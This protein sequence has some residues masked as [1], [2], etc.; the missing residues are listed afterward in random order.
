MGQKT[1]IPGSRGTDGFTLPEILISTTIALIVGA[2]A[3]TLLTATIKLYAENFSLNHSH[4]TTRLPLE[5]MIWEISDSGSAPIL[6]NDKG[7]D[8]TGVEQPSGSGNRWAPGIRFC[9][10]VNTTRYTIANSAT[11][12]ATSVNI[13]V[14]TGQLKP[15][16]SDILVIHASPVGKVGN[17][18]QAEI[19]TVTGASSPYTVTLK[20][21]LGVAVSANSSALILQ[22]GA[23]IAVGGQLRYYS[24]VMS[25]ARH[26]AAAFNAPANF[27]DLARV[28]AVPGEAEARPFSYGTTEDRMLRVDLRAR[29]T[30]YSNLDTRYSQASPN[31]NTFL[32]MRT[33]IAVKS[34]Y[35]DPTKLTAIQ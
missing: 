17:G 21:A 19:S 18:I 5:R 29:A 3:Y 32:N 15:R 28:E 6:V 27:R 11:A 10:L 25:E 1:R 7:A 31:F 26:G 30:K 12:T 23:F 35:L 16:D 2:A 33:S 4:Q 22:Q 13:N 20:S 14:A 8:T 34:T 9:T 24:K